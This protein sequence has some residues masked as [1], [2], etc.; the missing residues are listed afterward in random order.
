M[1]KSKNAIGIMQGRLTTPNG[2]GIQFF[3]F[4]NWRQEFKMAQKLGLEE[5]EFIFDLYKYRQNPLWSKTGRKTITSLVKKT[6][7]RINSVCADY[8]MRRP[9][10]RV[11]ENICQDNYLILRRLIKY[12]SEIG[13]S[14]I[15]IPLV[16]NSSIK[17]K[18]EGV[19]LVNVIQKTIPFL[20]KYHV[21]IGFETDLPP[22]KFLALIR[23]MDNPLVGANYDT[24]NSSSFGYDPKEEM[25]TFGKYIFNIHIKDRLYKGSTLALGEGDTQ[26]KRLYRYLNKF[27]YNG[28]FILQVA[29]G[30]DGDEI[31]TVKKQM[32]FLKKYGFK[33]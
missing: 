7:V 32:I 12:S 30:K 28:S 9:F 8:F 29:R 25:E 27:D 19:V 15:E 4:E 10:F 1:V 3:P 17:S 2:R 31:R 22:R 24:G 23:R 6:G 33:T 20:E 13:A 18:T 11:S 14:L 16:D 5:I 21:K 26:F